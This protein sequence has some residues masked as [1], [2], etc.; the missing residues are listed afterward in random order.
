[1]GN[2]N[3]NY[4]QTFSKQYRDAAVNLIKEYNIKVEKLTRIQLAKA[5]LQ[6]CACGDFHKVISVSNKG[7]SVIYIPYRE[8]EKLRREIAELRSQL[9]N[10]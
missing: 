3:T 2:T 1:M 7:Q 8:Y 5:F 6:A 9:D 10:K 4:M